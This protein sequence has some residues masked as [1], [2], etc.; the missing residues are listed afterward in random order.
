MHMDAI[1]KSPALLR[2]K[3]VEARTGLKR[4]KLYQ[5][6]AEGTF[7]AQ[8]KLGVGSSVAWVESD[9]EEWIQRQIENGRNILTK[10]PTAAENFLKEVLGNGE[11]SEPFLRG[12][13][14]TYGIKW[15]LIETARCNGIV[16]SES[17]MGMTAPRWRLL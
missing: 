11:M 13:A 15:E 4:S 9:V 6:M 17:V 2:R 14:E 16:T 1:N 5:L 12:K 3:D 10:Q 8:V 7:P